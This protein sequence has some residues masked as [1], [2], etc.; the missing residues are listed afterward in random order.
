MWKKS[1][2]LFLMVF[3]GF[4]LSFTIIMP[5]WAAGVDKYQEEL[6]KINKIIEQRKQ[7]ISSNKAQQKNVLE[8]LDV[9]SKDVNDTEQELE[10]LNEKIAAAQQEIGVAAKEL[11]KAEERL[12]E[13]TEILHKRLQSIYTEGQVSY[14]EVL[15]QATS[16]TDFLTRLDMMERIADQDLYLVEELAA[17][18]EQIAAKKARLEKNKKQLVLLQERTRIRQTYLA[19]RATE[20]K[21]LLSKLKT[22]RAAC[23]K[24]LNELEATSRQLTQIIQQAQSP[25]TNNQSTGRFIWPV[26]GYSTI[27]SD[28]GMRFHPILHR[29]KMHTGIDIGGAPSGARIVAADG[30]TV[31]YRGWLGGYG[32][33]VIIDHGKSY[34][35][36][37]AH[38][39]SFAVSKGQQVSQGQKIGG[40]GSTGW[41]TGPHLHFEV[42]INGVHQNPRNY[43]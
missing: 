1:R 10:G 15:F 34:S 35:T 25:G 7:Q 23:E 39:S 42:R 31:I 16:F 27:T 41:S 8:Q 18:Q 24:A 12:D 21:E 3:L 22:D 11:A 19:S 20:K 13:R 38:L 6:D 36:L 43:L 33:V 5:G 14:L 29:N 37:Y 30:G 9:L 17:Q 2:K 32:N 40:I 28:Y 26:P 4:V